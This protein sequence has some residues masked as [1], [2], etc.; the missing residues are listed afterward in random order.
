MQALAKQIL[1][2]LAAIHADGLT[3]NDIKPENIMLAKYT[4]HYTLK[5]ADH[6]HAHP[7]SI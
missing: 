2:S 6:S 1:V 3:H 5:D 7:Y 4:K